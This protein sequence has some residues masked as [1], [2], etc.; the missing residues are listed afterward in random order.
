MSESWKAL[1]SG[2][3]RWESRLRIL[4]PTSPEM[5]TSTRTL[6]DNSS[7]SAAAGRIYIV[8]R[9]G[10][11]T[12]T[13][14]APPGAC[15]RSDEE[16]LCSHCRMLSAHISTDCTLGTCW[17]LTSIY[18]RDNASNR[19]DVHNCSLRSHNHLVKHLDHSHRPEHIDSEHLFD[20][21]D[22]GIRRGHG[23]CYA[24]FSFRSLLFCMIHLG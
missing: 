13:A 20:F 4:L 21:A 6:P 18:V 15:C 2:S 10:N 12:R 7:V 17:L 5:I 9:K 1:P 3:V 23:V 11:L 24:Y 16:Q 19:A 8:E 14:S 22:F